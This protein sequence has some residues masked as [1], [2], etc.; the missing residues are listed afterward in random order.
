MAKPVEL[1][2]WHFMSY[3]YLPDNFDETQDTGWITV[4][5][6]LDVCDDARMDITNLLELQTWQFGSASCKEILFI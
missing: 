3:P 2:A 6:F 1:F 5:Q 4:F